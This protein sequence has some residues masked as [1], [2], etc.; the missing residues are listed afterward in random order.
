MSAL[1]NNLQIDESLNRPQ[2]FKKLDDF[3]WQLAA[4]SKWAEIFGK[5]LAANETAGELINRNIQIS[6]WRPIYFSVAMLLTQ[7]QLNGA[8]AIT[9]ENFQNHSKWILE[10]GNLSSLRQSVQIQLSKVDI[11]PFGV[12]EKPKTESANKAELET[13]FKGLAKNWQEAT[14]SYSLN[15]RRYSHPTYQVL[16]L[17]LGKENVGDVVPLILNELQHRPDVWFEALKVLTKANPAQNSKSF[18][19]AVAAWIAWGKKEKYIS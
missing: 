1:K 15:M 2:A 11:K 14:G 17:A 16:M 13:I 9:T 5:D 10:T 8:T 7:Q 18:D 12:D 3:D 6:A 19:D 4:Y